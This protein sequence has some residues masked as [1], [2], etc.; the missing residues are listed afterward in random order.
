MIHL[1]RKSFVLFASLLLA[2]A[3]VL[4][5]THRSK[6]KPP[7]DD[8]S[9]SRVR[10][11]T[12]QIPIK[13]QSQQPVAPEVVG[14][15]DRHVIAGGGGTS[16]GGS[17]RVDGTVGEVGASKPMTGGSLT[18]NGGFW[19]TLDGTATPSPTPTPSP[20]AGCS[21]QFSASNYNVGEA[22]GFATIAVAR[23]GDTSG[24]VTVDYQTSDL[25]A[26]QRTDY[27][28]GAGTVT[29][30]PG[31]SSKTFVVL[32]VNDL[33]VEGNEVLNLILSNP[34]GGATLVSPSVATLT[35]I[36]NDSSSPTTNPLDDARFFVQQHYYDFLSRYPDQ[37]GWDFWT[38]QITQCGTDTTC[39]RN[40]R[41]DVSNAYFY[42]LEYQQ[43][44]AY[45]FRLYRAAFGN[46][47]PFPNPDSSNQAEA[48]KLPSYAKFAFD[49]ARVVGGSSLAQ[50]QLDFAN[51]FVQRNEFKN[52]YSVGL[53]GPGFVDAVLA[54]IKNELGV[55][56][57]SQ[58]ATLIN[59]FN[60]GGRGAVMYRLADDNAQT[61]PVN[62]RAFI[63]EEYNRSFVFTQYAG[64]LRRDADIGGFL[65]WLGQVNSAPL[66]DTTKQH[67]MVCSFITSA[68]YQQRFSSVVTHANAECPQ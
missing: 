42:E 19:N 48:N 5:A 49:R 51:A 53:D 65:F 18:L 7:A 45:V 61:N 4:A 47:Q 58:R 10:T 14:P 44:G 23:T 64:Y 8:E 17:I 15:I 32:I 24:T 36:D 34:T 46:S 16:S 30:F 2:L 25:S 22:D 54:T 43:T 39:L 3:G 1:R 26:E 55:D 52:K 40:K 67:A 62:N 13:A 6:P 9:R 50:G 60:S 29:L 63:D 57:T 59:L 20:C 66:R 28:I 38:G 21:L 35:I 68:E 11:A 56:L 37:S 12:E 33:Y 31:E 27:T 41:I